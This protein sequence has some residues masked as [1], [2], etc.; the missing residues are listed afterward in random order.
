MQGFFDDESNCNSWVATEINHLPTLAISEFQYAYVLSTK[1]DGKRS[2]ELA[3]KSL[4]CHEETKTVVS[5]GFPWL[6]LGYGYS[7]LGEL[8]TARDCVEKGLNIH[9][10]YGNLFLVSFYYCALAMI[11]L[12]L[13][14][15]QNAQTYAEKALSSAQQNREKWL[16]SYS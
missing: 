15:S 7:V 4:K 6:T 10:E 8:E 5:L 14:D 16:E 9:L 1:G 3:Q 11:H 13:G 12:G 2:I